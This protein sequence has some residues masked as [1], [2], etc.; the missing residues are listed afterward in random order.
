MLKKIKKYIKS[1]RII[2]KWVLKRVNIRNKILFFLQN[3]S[4]D[5]K[6]YWEKRWKTFIQESYQFQIHD[7]HYWV[8]DKIKKYKPKTIL[9]IGCWFWRN[10]KF[11]KDNLDFPV[12]I[13]GIDISQELINNAKSF[14][15]KYENVHLQVSDI[16]SIDT[17]KAFDLILI[18]G[19][20]MHIPFDGF[21][22][23]RKKLHTL[24]YKHLIEVEEVVLDEKWI[25][26]GQNINGY[27]FS[28][29][30]LDLDENIVEKDIRNNLLYLDITHV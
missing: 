16:L 15:D 12:E 2:Y 13:M 20:F 7:S 4:Y 28:H 30:Y 22:E 10:I 23:N 26:R 18:H 1:H 9:E 27:T 17:S 3:G 14:L 8:L 29:N 6:K 19:V 21:L 11:L 25:I 24:N 5:A